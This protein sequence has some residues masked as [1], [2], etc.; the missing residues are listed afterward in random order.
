MLVTFVPFV[1]FFFIFVSNNLLY[2]LKILFE[3]IWMCKPLYED[4][5]RSA[6]EENYYSPNKFHFGLSYK[7]VI[8]LIHLFHSRKININQYKGHGI[9]N[10]IIDKFENSALDDFSLTKTEKYVERRSDIRERNY[11]V[12]GQ[13]KHKFPF[14]QF[15]NTNTGRGSNQPDMFPSS[16]PQNSFSETPNSQMCSPF[17]PDDRIAS[18]HFSTEKN[19]EIEYKP[20]PPHSSRYNPN[21]D[22]MEAP[23]LI[24]S[25][26][27]SS[28]DMTPRMAV[29]QEEMSLTSLHN[30]SGRQS[31]IS[32]HASVSGAHP[33][34]VFYCPDYFLLA[35]ESQRE[36][37]D[38][39]SRTYQRAEAEADE[40]AAVHG[41]LNADS[42]LG[43]LGAFPRS[44]PYRNIRDHETPELSRALSLNEFLDSFSKRIDGWSAMELWK[45][46]VDCDINEKHGSGYQNKITQLPVQL[47]ESGEI[48]QYDDIID[49]EHVEL[50]EPNNH[51]LAKESFELP[52]YDFRRRSTGQKY[53]GR[54]YSN[55]CDDICGNQAELM[56]SKKRKLVRPSF[57]E[58]HENLKAKAG[59]EKTEVEMS[60]IKFLDTENE[61][62]ANIVNSFFDSM[63]PVLQNVRKKYEPVGESHEQNNATSVDESLDFIPID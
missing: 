11:E 16:Y 50:R 56:E 58:M 4:E 61:S 10:K 33:K 17:L 52:F 20:S 47:I 28:L 31:R 42:D 35:E 39:E 46:S 9:P 18:R 22:D 24:Q 41:P 32:Q 3:R 5:F 59:K 14:D 40:Y 26:H 13:F 25:N 53:E 54:D 30:D 60:Y 51:V 57:E 49:S 63:V 27:H 1:S 38:R 62:K 48:D 45:K 43:L 6:I 7:Q 37:F 36:C 29:I 2:I 55:E 44:S 21:L 34:Q 12:R 23:Y 8:K 15:E 19:S